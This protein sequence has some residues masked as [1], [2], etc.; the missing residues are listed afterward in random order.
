MDI[1]KIKKMTEIEKALWNFYLFTKITEPKVKK[2]AK[3]K[4]TFLRIR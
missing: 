3:E 2:H 4:T 1:E